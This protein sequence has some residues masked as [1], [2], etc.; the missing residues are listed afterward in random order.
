[1]INSIRYKSTWLVILVYWSITFLVLSIDLRWGVYLIAIATATT[2]ILSIRTNIIPVMFL[3]SLMT[4]SFFSIEIFESHLRVPFI[5]NLF[6]LFSV[7]LKNIIKVFKSKILFLIITYIIWTLFVTSYTTHDL[8]DSLRIAIL[9][10]SLLLIS[11]NVAAIILSGKLKLYSATKIILYILIFNVMLGAM[12]YFGYF[13]FKIN[14]LNLNEIQW[15]QISIHHRMTATFWEGDTFGKY[16][17]AI[18]LLF[19][20]L[21]LNFL[22]NHIKTYLYVVLF[23][24]VILL[25]NK[26]R[27]AWIGLL[28]GISLFIIGM[29]KISFIKKGLLLT[30]LIIIAITTFYIVRYFEEESLTQRIRSFISFERIREDPSASFR[31]ETVEDTWEM[32]KDDINTLIF[33]HGYIAMGESWK[34][35]SNIF[36]HVWLTSGL[37]GLV[38]FILS[39]ALFTYNCLKYKPLHLENKLVAQGALLS[40]SGMITASLLA[41]MFIDPIFWMIIGFGVYFELTRT[42]KLPAM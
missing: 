4:T 31:I 9:P 15:E 22:K 38:F 37:I 35:V 6:V 33:G 19:I 11:V 21:S 30:L 40:M 32:I 16:L 12:Q 41:P 7:G 27:S 13:V 8:L 39:I 23:A 1:M 29:T 10:T 42:P 36:L 20:P 25:L 28:S 18:I 2:L 3:V 14:L 34:G 26:T 24:N 5:L 17:M